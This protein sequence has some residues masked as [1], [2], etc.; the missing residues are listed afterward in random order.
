MGTWGTEKFPGASGRWVHL[1]RPL[2]LRGLEYGVHVVWSPSTDKKIVS[3]RRTD[4]R[5]R[6]SR[7]TLVVILSKE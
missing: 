4:G 5:G 2:P 1:L 7:E 6:G 3:W